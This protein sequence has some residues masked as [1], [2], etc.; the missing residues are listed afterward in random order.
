MRRF[1]AEFRGMP[2]MRRGD[3]AG[4][5]GRMTKRSAWA[6]VFRQRPKKTKWHDLSALPILN[7]EAGSVRN[8]LFLCQPDISYLEKNSSLAKGTYIYILP[9]VTSRLGEKRYT[10][11]PNK[12]GG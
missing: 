7:S 11:T 2:T 6:I 12:P 4:V 10:S 9:F 3:S 1:V 5:A 8:T